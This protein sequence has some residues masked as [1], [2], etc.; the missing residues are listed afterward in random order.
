[1]KILHLSN[2]IGKLK[3]GGVHEVVCNIYKS[4]KELNHVPHIWYPGKYSDSDSIRLDNNVKALETYGNI[5]FGLVKNIFQ[6]V[7]QAFNEYDVIHQHGIWM[8]ISI[9]SNK[10]GSRTKVIRLVQP[11]GYLEPFCLR[12][13]KMKKLFAYCAYER[14]NILNADNIVA[15][16]V[17]EGLNLKKIFPMKTISIIPNGISSEFYNEPSNKTKNNKGPKKIVYL[18]QIIPVKGLERFFKVIK[19]IDSEKLRGWEI[20]ISGYGS[21]PYVKSLKLLVEHLNL[22]YLIKFIGPK[23]DKEKI[24][25]IDNAKIF[26]LPTYN[27]NYGIV[28]AEAM[29][30]GIPVITT[31]GAPWK[32]INTNSCGLWVENN[33]KGLK[34]GILELIEATDQQLLDMGNRGRRLI[35]KKYMWSNA[36]KKTITLYK[37]LINGIEKPDFVL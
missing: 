24:E 1:M 20:L 32:E 33:C 23:V 6:K 21:A 15:C 19:D 25:L 35:S 10:I 30:R 4:Q 12:L 27:E 2:V 17:N 28:V 3:G 14:N 26:I 29:A 11:H 22:E 9:Y 36:A 8:P 37:W 16:S 31:Q 34:S 7:D 13:S 18:S 5:K